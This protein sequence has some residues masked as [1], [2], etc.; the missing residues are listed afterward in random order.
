MSG[1]FVLGKKRGKKRCQV[2]LFCSWE[3]GYTGRQG[4]ANVATEGTRACGNVKKSKRRKVKIRWHQGISQ[5]NVEKSKSRNKKALGTVDSYQLSAVPDSDTDE[6][7]TD[8]WFYCFDVLTFR[9]FDVLR[10]LSPD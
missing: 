6:I 1:S 5:E 2:H 9:L 3:I 10:K 4:F 8:L 7:G